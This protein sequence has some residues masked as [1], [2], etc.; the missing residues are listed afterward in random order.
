MK[1]NEWIAII[2]VMIVV[3]VIVA[4]TTGAIT[5]N[6]VKVKDEGK[7]GTEVYTKAEV[8]M[9][10][11]EIDDTITRIYTMMDTPLSERSPCLFLWG[12]VQSSIGANR[13]NLEYN[14][15]ADVNNDGIINPTDALLIA[16]ANMEGNSSWCKDKMVAMGGTPIK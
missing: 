1:T 7:R 2:I 8:D 12:L 3:S 16:N 14:L 5:G 6:V 4:Y 15:H 13:S 9:F 11:T 10:I